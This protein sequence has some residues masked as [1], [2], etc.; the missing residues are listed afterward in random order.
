[1]FNPIQTREKEALISTFYWLKKGMI[2]RI[3]S[4]LIAKLM[5]LWVVG[6]VGYLNLLRCFFEGFSSSSPWSF[7]VPAALSLSLFD[8]LLCLEFVPLIQ[9]QIIARE[10]PTRAFTNELRSTQKHEILRGF[11]LEKSTWALEWSPPPVESEQFKISS[12][13]SYMMYFQILRHFKFIPPLYWL[14]DEKHG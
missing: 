8:F 6:F 7:F 12:L 5:E 9:F 1:M 3:E 2:L 13:L 11:N 14:F 10:E 4:N